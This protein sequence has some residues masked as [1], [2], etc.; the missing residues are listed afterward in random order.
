MRREF[1]NEVKQRPLCPAARPID[2]PATL[3]MHQRFPH[4]SGRLG[5]LRD[6]THPC[7]RGDARLR[8]VVAQASMMARFR[9]AFG[10]QEAS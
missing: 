4:S 10:R 1:R 5:P 3:P 2:R 8:Q 6:G 9:A 7:S